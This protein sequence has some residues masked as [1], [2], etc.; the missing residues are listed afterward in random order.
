MEV[1]TREIS[2]RAFGAY[3]EP[4]ENVTTVRY[5]GLVAT[6]VDDDWIAVLGNLRK[7]QK[8]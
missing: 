6:A 8:S 5:L 1:E 3:G 4:L 7:A 2:E